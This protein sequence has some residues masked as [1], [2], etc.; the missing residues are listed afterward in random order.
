MNI[1]RMVKEFVTGERTSKEEEENENKYRFVLPDLSS[2]PGASLASESGSPIS[3]A[4]LADLLNQFGFKGA[5]VDI[6]TGPTVTLYRIEPHGNQSMK[7]LSRFL[8]DIALRLGAESAR[9]LGQLPGEKYIGIEITNTR[10]GS[11]GL[12]DMFSEPSWDNYQIPVSLGVG[13]QGDPVSFDLADAPHLLVAGQ[14]GS[15]KSVFINSFIASIL[16]TR[17]PYEVNFCMID[18]KEVELSPYQDIAHNLLPV[19]VNAESAGIVLQT[20]LYVME[21]RYARMAKCGLTNFDDLNARIKR[22]NRSSG[23]QRIVVII[24]EFADLIMINPHL[25]QPIIRLAQKARAAGIHLILATQRPV[26]KVV[27][28]L[29]KANIPA[30][31]AFRTSSAIDSRVILD[32]KGAEKLLGS[33]DLLY[34]SSDFPSPIRAQAPFAPREQIQPL[35]EYWRGSDCKIEL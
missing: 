29:I 27:T 7:T 16:A 31:L 13:A 1:R 14:T 2:I 6:A 28:G 30:R 26:V 24:D 33:G 17:L 32:E 15:G 19:A 23:I 25:E 4:K 21:Q 34:K 11:V 3:P 10:R 18:P 20:M 5:V 22:V 8:P 35:I 9:F 12:L